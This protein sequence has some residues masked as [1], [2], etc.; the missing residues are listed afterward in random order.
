MTESTTNR[1]KLRT[2]TTGARHII[3]PD[4]TNAADQ[5]DGSRVTTRTADRMPAF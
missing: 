2:D 5:V 1:K 3:G 4:L